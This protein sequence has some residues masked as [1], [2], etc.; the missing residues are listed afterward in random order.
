M[1]T[2]RAHTI[3]LPLYAEPCGASGAPLYEIAMHDAGESAANTRCNSFAEGTQNL[4]DVYVE[5]SHRSGNEYEATSEMYYASSSPAQ[6]A[7]M[8]AAALK[9]VAAR[10]QAP[11]TPY[12]RERGDNLSLRITQ[13]KRHRKMKEWEKKQR[14]ITTQFQHEFQLS[15]EKK[16]DSDSGKVATAAA[17]AATAVLYVMPS[18]ISAAA[19]TT[20][21]SDASTVIAGD[22]K[23]VADSDD[24]DDDGDEFEMVIFP[25]WLSRAHSA[26]DTLI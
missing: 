22:E 2:Q 12:R 3:E 4:Y 14:E 9:F 8:Q 16:D 1:T 18:D 26:S 15:K 7:Q 19:A 21:S 23:D 5:R 17:A 6:R 20:A 11:A 25:Q 24:S 10:L 13:Q